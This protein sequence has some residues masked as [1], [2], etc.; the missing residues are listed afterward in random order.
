M[1]ISV[2]VRRERNPN[3]RVLPPG[4]GHVR[5]SDPRVFIT[6]TVP[7]GQPGYDRRLHLEREYYLPL[8]EILRESKA[9]LQERLVAFIQTA[10][11][12]LQGRRTLEEQHDA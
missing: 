1:A 2:W 10:V 7:V 5:G 9:V 12:H 11:D 6:E 3:R 8:D 4:K